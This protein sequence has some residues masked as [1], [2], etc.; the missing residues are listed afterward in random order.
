MQLS[1]C[2]EPCYKATMVSAENTN[3]RLSTADLLFI[4]FG[5][6][7]VA[8]VELVSA[9]LIWK[10]VKQEVSCTVILSLW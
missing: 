6:A 3:L 1:I 4:L 9:L 10:P 5:K 7:Y 8:Y 2:D